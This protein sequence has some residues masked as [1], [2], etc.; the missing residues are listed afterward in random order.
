MA[1]D[2]PEQ[3]SEKITVPHLAAYLCM[4]GRVASEWA[5]LEFYLDY[6]IWQ[7]AKVEQKFGA[8]M[9]SQIIG[10]GAKLR[11]TVAL[12]RLR[13]IPEATVKK[14]LQFEGY[15]Q[16]LGLDRNRVVHDTWVY[17]SENKI[18]Q[19]RFAI[20]EKRLEFG[21]TEIAFGGVVKIHEKIQKA[22]ADLRN[23]I[24]EVFDVFSPSPGISPYLPRQTELRGQYPPTHHSDT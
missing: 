16:P 7:L 9:T 1:S 3:N 17:G 19:L 2:E 10:V 12:L 22:G 15:V 13:E 4:A 24:A 14:F 21:P 8:C 18:L 23:L 5:S 11:S 6:L 20:T